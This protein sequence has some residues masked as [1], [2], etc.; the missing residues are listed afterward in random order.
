MKKLV[1]FTMLMALVSIVGAQTHHWTPIT[2]NETTMVV[3]GVIV[4]DG[5]EQ[6]STTLEI[7][8][9]CGSE[10]RGS[11]FAQ[12]FPPTQQYII[13]M[14]IKSAPGKGETITFALYDHTINQELNLNCV[15]TVEYE[16]N[17][18]IGTM[19]NWFQFAFTT[20]TTTN[21]TSGDWSNPATWGGT[22][23][24]ATANVQVN[25][26]N[27]TIG[28]NGAVDVTVAS[29]EIGSGAS[30][31]IE[32][33][34]TLIV[35]D[36]LVNNNVNGLVIEDGAQVISSSAGVKATLKK[37]IDGYAKA[38]S[39][40]YTIS[41]SVNSMLIEGSDFLTPEYDLYRY[42]ETAVGG[43]W[44]NYKDNS[45]SGFTA[46]ENGR[47]YLY[48]NENNITPAFTGTLNNAAINVGV[49]Y[50]PR[51]DGLS[52][53]NLIGNPF[54]HVIYKGAGGAID[55][56]KLAS[57]FYTL[58][59]EGAWHVNT[60]E[61]AIQPGQGILVKTTEGTTLNIAKTTTAA[62]KESSTRE[63]PGRIDLKVKGNNV[64]DR[65]YVY[66]CNGIG[67]E[68]MGNLSENEPSL[69]IRDNGSYY[70][71]THVNTGY[72]SLD[73]MFLNRISGEFTFG[74]GFEGLRFSYL[75]LVDLVAGAEVDLLQNPD[76]TFTATG[77]E[78]TARFKLVF[79][80][81]TGVNETP[82]EALF[83]FV[84]DGQI[85][86]NGMNEDASLQIVDVT[87]RI[88]ITR[89]GQIQ[90]VSTDG[91]APGVYVLR[92]MEENKVRTQ[93]IVVK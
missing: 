68:K 72:E 77:N 10:C 40:W 62:T 92:L 74:V 88:I 44:E 9:F 54:P 8:A 28:D 66:F 80:V 90:S 86:V 15:N 2:G 63:A 14:T 50:T 13:T 69:F 56:A 57:G 20:P 70:A 75:H 76:Y 83:A 23:P 17:A 11:E 43:E 33:G 79:R 89:K 87:G 6:Q 32:A 25:T 42:N 58:T 21:T 24:S 49:T 36:D 5:V 67:L 51:T 34:S 52:G 53:F 78:P 41:S 59:N 19:N 26:G 46:F 38:S 3:K 65:A 84:S 22:A 64:E 82:E 4:I 73:L 91:M 29:L 47:G 1:L 45:N 27:V 35:T 81:T 30:V 61:N 85:F 12:Y 55:D 37:S 7:G 18:T 93:K 60:Y 31:T 16:A 39:G 48:A 71:I